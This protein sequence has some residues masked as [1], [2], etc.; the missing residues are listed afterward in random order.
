MSVN[1]SCSPPN[2]QLPIKPGKGLLYLSKDLLF[3]KK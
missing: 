2:T 1:G 3:L